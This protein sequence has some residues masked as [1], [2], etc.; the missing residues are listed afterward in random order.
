M[1]ESFVRVLLELWQQSAMTIALGS[2]FH[3]HHWV[4][5]HSGTETFPDNKPELPL[6]CVSLL[7]PQNE[8]QL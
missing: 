2:L 8:L 7:V 3:T 6:M 4:L 1:S 5:H